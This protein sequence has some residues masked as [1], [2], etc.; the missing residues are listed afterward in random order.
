[1]A[2]VYTVKAGTTRAQAEAWLK[3]LP[4]ELEIIEHWEDGSQRAAA[5]ARLMAQKHAIQEFLKGAPK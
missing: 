5:K 3:G 4:V 2:E 1:M